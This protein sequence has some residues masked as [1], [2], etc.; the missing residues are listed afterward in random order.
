M[1][2]LSGAFEKTH[3]ATSVQFRASTFALLNERYYYY[4]YYWQHTI[5]RPNNEE[6]VIWTSFLCTLALAKQQHLRPASQPA[7]TTK[8][9]KTSF[10]KK[11]KSIPRI[12]FYSS[13]SFLKLLA[14]VVYYRQ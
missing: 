8:G 3:T 4:Y 13:K 1:T 11:K 12:E 7:S 2:F 5:W 14:K 6:V 10:F 9:R